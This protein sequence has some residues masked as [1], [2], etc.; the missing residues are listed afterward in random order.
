MRVTDSAENI[1]TIHHMFLQV[2]YTVC[3][4][5]FTFHKAFTDISKV[6]SAGIYIH[7]D[8]VLPQ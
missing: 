4:I 3:G 6:R 5:M 7:R 8:S 1:N 2:Y